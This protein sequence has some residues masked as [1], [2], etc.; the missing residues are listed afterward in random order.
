MMP[1][2]APRKAVMARWSVGLLEPA[3]AGVGED[4]DADGQVSSLEGGRESG[5]S[6]GEGEEGDQLLAERLG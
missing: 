2:A 1:E 4:P 6:S 3:V 5:Y